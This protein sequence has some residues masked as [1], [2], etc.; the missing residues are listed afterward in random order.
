MYLALILKGNKWQSND[1]IS[2][3]RV[4]S[5]SGNATTTTHAQLH[6]IGLIGMDS[7]SSI[8]DSFR[9]NSPCPTLAAPFVAGVTHDPP[10]MPFIFSK[11]IRLLELKVTINLFRLH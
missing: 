8:S 10:D 11:Q 4:H 9:V 6:Q 1:S 2:E 3:Y 5:V 7:Y